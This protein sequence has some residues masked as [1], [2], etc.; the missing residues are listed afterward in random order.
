[1]KVINSV[2]LFSDDKRY[3]KNKSV[4]TTHYT[5]DS[6]FKNERN[7]NQNTAQADHYMTTKC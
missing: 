1:M 6:K 7:S 3:F 5:N 2:F 4:T